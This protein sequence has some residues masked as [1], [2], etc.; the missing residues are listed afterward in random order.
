ML[1]I[2]SSSQLG[3]TM[4]FLNWIT[5]SQEDNLFSRFLTSVAFSKWHSN[6][7]NENFHCTVS[8]ICFEGSLLTDSFITGASTFTHSKYWISF[9]VFISVCAYH[10]D[11]RCTTRPWV[12]VISKVSAHKWEQKNLNLKIG[13]G[14]DLHNK[15]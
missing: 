1:N 5:R 8:I 2:T 3:A 13:V 14:I 12:S 10:H 7:K 11:G 9:R 6:Y 15:K 4:D